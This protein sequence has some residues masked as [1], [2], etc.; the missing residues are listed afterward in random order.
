AGRAE[1]LHRL[2]QA[3]ADHAYVLDIIIGTILMREE[4]DR[5]LSAYL[6]SLQIN[7][8]LVSPYHDLGLI[9]ANAYNLDDAY[10]CWDFARWLSPNHPI[11][12]DVEAREHD[13]L[14]AEA[15]T[16]FG[17]FVSV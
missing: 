17:K 7:P 10:R 15:E 16:P 3:A 6:A 13:I 5:A 14:A 4:P 9:F 1:E 8:R 11:M 12:S 2:R